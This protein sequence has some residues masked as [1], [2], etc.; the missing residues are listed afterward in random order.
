M[1][2]SMVMKKVK[3]KL[4]EGFIIILGVVF[5]NFDKLWENSKE[6]EKIVKFYL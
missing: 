4:K 5:F 1:T 6:V 2:K 3:P